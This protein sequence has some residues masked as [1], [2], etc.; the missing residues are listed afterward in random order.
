MS[1]SPWKKLFW[2]AWKKHSTELRWWQGVRFSSD[3]LLLLF[4]RSV[5]SNSL[6]PH[7]LHA[8][9]Q[10][11]LSF[12]ISQSLLRLMSFEL[13]IPSNPL[14][15]CRPLLLLPSI[16]PSI[17]VFS[18]ELALRIRQPKYWSFNQGLLHCRRILYHLSYQGSLLMGSRIRVM[19]PK[20][21][22]EVSGI[23][24]LD[25]PPRF[26]LAF[27]NVYIWLL[28]RIVIRRLTKLPWSKVDPPRIEPGGSLWGGVG[29]AVLTLV[30]RNALGGEE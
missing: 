6:W 30:V 19:E 16:F 12:T 23:Y 2:P 13:V 27:F 21:S 1:D 9:H 25:F 20:F 18:N 29:V 26:Y 7:G 11:P 14:V 3:G 10:A 4:N 22:L 17:R 15:F 8:A 24:L 5:V 28:I